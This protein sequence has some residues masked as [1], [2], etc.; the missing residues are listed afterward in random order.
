MDSIGRHLQETTKIISML[1]QCIIAYSEPS[2]HQRKWT[3]TFI[4]FLGTTPAESP[5]QPDHHN[6]H[7]YATPCKK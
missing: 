4:V 7:Q 3:S 1:A 6:N 5:K 2:V